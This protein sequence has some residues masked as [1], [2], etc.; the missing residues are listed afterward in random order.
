MALLGELVLCLYS[1][2]PGTKTRESLSKLIPNPAFRAKTAFKQNRRL[3][4]P[5]PP[6]SKATEQR[7]GFPHNPL[8]EL[9]AGAAG[10][11]SPV[12]WLCVI[13]PHSMLTSTR[14]S[15]RSGF[16]YRMPMHMALVAAPNPE[17]AGSREQRS[18]VHKCP[19]NVHNVVQSHVYRSII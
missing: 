7:V 17:P 14:V 10:T 4:S 15:R 18:N 19:E 16:Q 1:D 2:M 11:A 5:S 6:T 3:K 12:G 8:G 13:L 9:G